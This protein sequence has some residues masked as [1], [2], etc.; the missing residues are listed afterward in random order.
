MLKKK[1]LCNE[2]KTIFT[3]DLQVLAPQESK[4]IQSI[5]SEKTNL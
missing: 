1:K 2:D 3:K 5:A 4:H